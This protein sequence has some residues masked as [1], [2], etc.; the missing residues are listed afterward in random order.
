VI[1]FCSRLGGGNPPFDVKRLDCQGA[2]YTMKE[3]PGFRQ[4]VPSSSVNE[5]RLLLN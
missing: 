1:T 2:S 5:A 3:R 4:G